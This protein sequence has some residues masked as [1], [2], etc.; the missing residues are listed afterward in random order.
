MESKLFQHHQHHKIW[1]GQ[2][3]FYAE[4]IGIF[5]KELSHIM[6]VYSSSY[7][8]IEHAEEYKRIFTKKKVLIES[9]RAE[10]NRHEKQISTLEGKNVRQD[11]SHEEMALKIEAFVNKIESFKKNFRRFTAKHLH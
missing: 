4:E 9:M 6:D 11:W 3:D 1:L 5:F 2:L 8:V 10:I 7:S